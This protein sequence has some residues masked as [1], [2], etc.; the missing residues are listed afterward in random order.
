MF[1]SDYD[2]RK[3]LMLRESESPLRER[4]LVAVPATSL[5]QFPRT[6]R[7]PVDRPT[8]RGSLLVSWT[9]NPNYVLIFLLIP[10]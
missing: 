3:Q 2:R 4:E 7:T 8:R 10:P 9:S 1:F 6:R 5:T